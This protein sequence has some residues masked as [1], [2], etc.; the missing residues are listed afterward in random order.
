[1]GGQVEAERANN[2]NSELLYNGMSSFPTGFKL[3][4][5]SLWNI[6]LTTWISVS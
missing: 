3:R 4:R 2:R 1:M 6:K 5:L